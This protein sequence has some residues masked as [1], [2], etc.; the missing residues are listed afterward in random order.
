MSDDLKE[1]ACPCCSK[2][3]Y[4]VAK[5]TKKG[6]STWLITDSSPSVETDSLGHFIKC[7]HCSKRVAMEPEIKLQGS[8]FH[9]SPVQKCDQTLP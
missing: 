2:P 7:P 1:V 9:L 4:V 3:L 8:G 5:V 6:G